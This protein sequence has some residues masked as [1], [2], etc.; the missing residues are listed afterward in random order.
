MVT[1]KQDG[2]ASN[3]DWR[4]QRFDTGPG[5]EAALAQA[6]PQ[7]SVPLQDTVQ[8]NS[9]L[10]GDDD[11]GVGVGATHVGIG[12]D[13]ATLNAMSTGSHR[14]S[15]GIGAGVA[16]APV[17]GFATTPATMTTATTT[18]STTTPY[19][20]DTDHG[21]CPGCP[22]G[23]SLCLGAGAVMMYSPYGSGWDPYAP[24]PTPST[25]EDF[26]GWSGVD[27]NDFPAAANRLVGHND[28]GHYQHPGGEGNVFGVSENQDHNQLD[29]TFSPAG[30]GFSQTLQHSQH[31][32]HQ[33]QTHLQHSW[34]G[35]AHSADASALSLRVRQPGP[36]PVM[37]LGTGTSTPM[38]A[39]APGYPSSQ[40]EGLMSFRQQQHYSSSSNSGQPQSLQQQPYDGM[41]RHQDHHPNSI[42][43]SPNSDLGYH[44]GYYGLVAPTETSPMANMA[45][46][47]GMER[48]GASASSQQQHYH[49]GFN[50]N[51]ESNNN[52][53]IGKLG[54]DSQHG[55]GHRPP[56]FVP[57]MPMSKS[58]PE[59]TSSSMK[60]NIEVSEV[61]QNIP[62]C[63]WERGAPV[64][65][66]H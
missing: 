48:N 15:D 51:H 56:R 2:V 63:P 39:G 23:C 36:V 12:H 17:A 21:G 1:R 52:R 34:P 29:P 5:T 64:P 3:S 58:M 7:S 49:Q 53:M 13:A 19:C 61:L 46:G 16:V 40:Q 9:H 42:I 26:V 55:H 32:V 66:A 65:L 30:G 14:G 11:A 50:S 6:L 28:P 4:E 43:A 18:T 44:H 24:V 8:H 57:S 31:E 62:F 10:H 37:P 59:G 54:L 38:V 25:A 27:G 60:T 41:V 33:A 20:L 47:M 45:L 35:S 22:G